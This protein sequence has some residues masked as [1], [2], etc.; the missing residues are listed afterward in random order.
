MHTKI[1]DQTKIKMLRSEGILN[2][3]LDDAILLTLFDEKAALTL[4]KS[5]EVSSLK[6]IIYDNYYVFYNVISKIGPI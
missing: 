1:H 5:L 2:C 3:N 6:D 4:S